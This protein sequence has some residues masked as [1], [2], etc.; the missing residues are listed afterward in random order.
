MSVE[1]DVEELKRLAFIAKLREKNADAEPRYQRILRLAQAL[2]HTPI[3]LISLVD[4]DVQWFKAKLGV[5]LCETARA[6]AFCAHAILQQELLVIEDASKDARFASNPLVLN[7]PYIRFYAGAQIRVNKHYT[8]GTLCVIDDKPR[9]L[10]AEAAQHLQD[11]ADIIAAEFEFELISEQIRAVNKIQLLTECI[12]RVQADFILA[13]DR[14]AAFDRLLSDIL[15]L[16]DSGYGFIG[17]VLYDQDQAPYLKTFALTNIAWDDATRRFYAE[18]APSGLEFRNLQ[19]LF[20]YTL[21]TGQVII[22]NEPAKNVHACGIPKG[23]PPLDAYVG[24]PI[25]FDDKLIAMVGLA[26]KPGGYCEKDVEFLK[27]LTSTVGQLVYAVR[28]KRQQLAVQQ[29]LNNIVAASEIGTWT[30]DLKSEML[31]VNPRW[32]TMLGYQPQELPEVSL[33]WMRS[34]M[35]P[36][37]LAASRESVREHLEGSLDFYESQFRIRH[38]AG[39]WVWVQARGRIISQTDST[40]NAPKLYGINIDITAEK[41]LQSRLTKLAANV[42]GMVYQFQLNPDKSIVFPY[43]GPAVDCLLGFSAAE[44]ATNGEQVFS[45]IH[46]EDLAPLYDSIMHSAQTLKQ[47]Q[48]RFRLAVHGTYYRWLAGQSTP[49]RQDNGAVI[50]H[51]YIQ[52]VTE[53]MEMQFALEQAKAQAERAVATKSS[54]LANMSHEIRTPMNGVIGMLD[55]LAESNTDPNQAESIGLMRDSAYSLLTIIDDILDFSKLEAGKLNISKEACQLAP[56]IEQICSMLDYLALKNQVELTYYIDPAIDTALWFDPNRV[57]QILVNL[58]SNAIKFSSNLDRAGQV[59]LEVTLADKQQQQALLCFVVTDNGIGMAPEVVARLFQPFTQAD[60]STSRKYGGTGLG[61]AIT[62]Q[63]VQLMDGVITAESTPG[64][65]SLFK[66][67]IPVEIALDATTLPK[68]PLAG[69]KVIILGDNKQR[70]L[71][72]CAHYLQADGAEIQWLSAS[73]LSESW[74]TTIT[75]RVVWLV[76]KAPSHIDSLN[77]LDK[78]KQY[79]PENSRFV[80]LGRGRR[81]KARRMHS[82]TVGIDAN[83]LQRAQLSQAV[84]AAYHDDM[85]APV[86]EKLNAEPAL[87]RQHHSILVL[88]DNTTNQ[89]VIKQQLLRLGYRVEVAED[90]LIGLSCTRKQHFDLILSDLH[91]PN[92]DGYQF[93][94]AYRAAEQAAGR[95][96]IPVIALTANIVPEELARCKEEGMDDYLVK[97][98]PVSQLKACLETWLKQTPLTEIV[99]VHPT[100][101]VDEALP[102]LATASLFDTRVLAETVGEDAV[103]EILQDYVDALGQG[104]SK[105]EQAMAFNQLSLVAQESHKLKSSS[106]FVGAEQLADAF[107][108]LEHLIKTESQHK[109]LA[110]AITP[111]FRH[112]VKLANAVIEAINA[113]TG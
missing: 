13:E 68:R 64:L 15:Q 4:R 46:P 111:A 104:I 61:L 93:V 22:A 91:M 94:R 2:L 66:V 79:Q 10:T 24:I 84:L 87:Q 52:D 77:A 59:R 80:L 99:P 67:V 43:V 7:A 108:Q 51:G 63:L 19:S 23:H 69:L 5:T 1:Y 56:G 58:L 102:A 109:D 30:L 74:L 11:L 32:L 92:M 75:G 72:D 65:G 50:W 33:S 95:P 17:E 62:H 101:S 88:E 14:R 76:D 97:P 57:R 44:L 31:V 81:R 34:N 48:L 98:L 8:L 41:T 18:N 54:F 113:E 28:I 49:E 37:D 70:V 42:P 25:F 26:N 3:V 38:K 96:R 78:I 53:E 40:S 105:I 12:A 16:T 47:W 55:I 73:A 39:H 90:G 21:R 27:P 85:T 45:K 35:H 60:D 110:A 29:Q 82:D 9:S 112:L 89:K 36:D 106:R 103:P 20:G 71:N 107:V 86:E 6:D 83:V 100:L